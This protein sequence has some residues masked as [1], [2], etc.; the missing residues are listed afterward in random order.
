MLK[1]SKFE[2][3][4]KDFKYAVI[5]SSQQSN[6][7]IVAYDEDGKKVFKKAINFKGIDENGPSYVSGPQ[8][9][10]NKYYIG[11]ISS[12]KAQDKIIILDENLNVEAIPGHEYTNFALN[13]SYMYIT[14]TNVNEGTTLKQINLDT[15]EVEKETKISGIIL[16]E[17]IFFED[18][19]ILIGNIESKTYENMKIVSLS[20]KD[21]KINYEKVIENMKLPHGYEVLNNK[22]YFIPTID[23]L[24][25]DIKKLV[26][27]DREKKELEEE[28]IPLNN[29]RFIK[30]INNRLYGIQSTIDN[31]ED[32]MFI[33]D[34][35][36]KEYKIINLQHCVREVNFSENKIT[37]ASNDHVYVYDIN[38]L[39][40]KKNF[41]YDDDDLMFGTLIVR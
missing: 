28:D 1:W 14:Y 31:G 26:V 40:L 35:K 5:N 38:N 21:F 9:Y 30:I 8:K 24:D 10:N 22:V 41:K 27:Y 32:S 13:N 7:S 2:N 15:N 4:N 19:I 20:P 17:I 6:G 33:L 12:F 36:S 11:A 37:M 18:E 16:P 25:N 3:K 34:L 39:K 29:I 23:N